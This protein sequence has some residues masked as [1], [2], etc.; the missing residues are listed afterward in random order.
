MK[1]LEIKETAG[2]VGKWGVDGINE[3]GDTDLVDTC[4][5]RELF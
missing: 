4:A 2:V 1:G 3:N 5:E